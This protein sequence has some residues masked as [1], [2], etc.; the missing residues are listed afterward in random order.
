MPLYLMRGKAS[1]EVQNS[2]DVGEVL[3]LEEKGDP[4]LPIFTSLGSFSV[5]VEAHYAD[6]ERVEVTPLR[7]NI[8]ELV[9][10]AEAMEKAGGPEYVVLDPKTI[11]SGKWKR[12]HKPIPLKGVCRFMNEIRP[13][14]ETLAEEASA[15]VGAPGDMEAFR[16]E[17]ERNAARIDQVAGDAIARIAE[18]EVEEDSERNPASKIPKVGRNEPCPCGSGKKYKKCHGNP[19]Y[20]S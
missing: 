13:G 15:R 1:A 16:R 19:S 3:T 9:D 7:I 10:M 17:I 6:K 20:P 14:V 2:R 5:F 12:M 11:S 8:F 4:V 18:W